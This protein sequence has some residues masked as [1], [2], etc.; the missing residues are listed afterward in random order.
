[1]KGIIVETKKPGVHYVQAR[2][3]GKGWENFPGVQ[4]A[5]SWALLMKKSARAEELELTIRAIICTMRQETKYE[6][7]F[8]Y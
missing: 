7:V 6:T 2:V 4:D 8:Q 1:M 5:Q 3:S